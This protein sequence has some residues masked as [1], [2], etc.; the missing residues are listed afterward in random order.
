[1]VFCNINSNNGY[2]WLQLATQCNVGDKKWGA[3]AS[4]KGTQRP[5]CNLSPPP[6]PPPSPAAAPP[7]CPPTHCRAQW[8]RKG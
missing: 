2:D 8:Q 3:T 6:L 5:I 7:C 4:Q 1:M